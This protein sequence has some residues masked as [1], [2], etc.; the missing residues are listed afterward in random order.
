ARQRL[1]AA[2]EAEAVQWH[3]ARAV[4]ALAEQ[5]QEQYLIGGEQTVLALSAFDLERAHIDAARRWAQQHTE[6]PEGNQLLLDAAHA[7]VSIGECRFDRMHEN[8]PF[9]DGVRTAARRLGDRTTEGRALNNL[10]NA[11]AS[12]GQ[13]STALPYLE[14]ALAIARELSHRLGEV[15]V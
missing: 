13:P 1:E 9:W 14:Q 12:L 10:A 11:Y 5:I 6:T 2:G 4:V 15:I 3:Y 8:I 7:T